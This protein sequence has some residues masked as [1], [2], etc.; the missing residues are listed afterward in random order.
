[1]TVIIANSFHL[2][3]YL[4][5]TIVDRKLKPLIYINYTIYF[6]FINSVR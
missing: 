1:M 3:A 4:C 6:T 2:V 5:Y